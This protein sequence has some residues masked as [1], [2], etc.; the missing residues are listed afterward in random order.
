MA[1]LNASVD[2]RT[3]HSD[4]RGVNGASPASPVGSPLN[5]ASRRTRKASAAIH[6]TKKMLAFSRSLRLLLQ[7]IAS[8]RENQ[9]GIDEYAKMFCPKAIFLLVF[10]KKQ[11]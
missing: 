3:R 6:R 9:K 10:I 4:T 1:L 8:V 11:N 5:A 2:F 7:S